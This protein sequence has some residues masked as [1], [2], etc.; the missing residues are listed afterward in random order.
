MFCILTPTEMISK[1]I[2]VF[3]VSTRWLKTLVIL[4]LS[5][6]FF[7]PRPETV[8]LS[9][10]HHFR[11]LDLWWPFYPALFY[12]EDCHI[13]RRPSELIRQQHLKRTGLRQGGSAPESGSRWLPNFDGEFLVHTSLVK[14]SWTCYRF[15]S[16]DTRESVEKNAIC[17]NVE[18]SFEKFLDP[19]P[20]ADDFQ[21]FNRFLCQRY[22]SSKIFVKIRSVA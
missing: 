14:S 13:S 16:R 15:L 12:R 20:D 5:R 21:T 10:C 7:S 2:L 6:Q 1:I 3:Y 17:C 4:S 19:H 11:H 9:V 22:I 8:I 18:R